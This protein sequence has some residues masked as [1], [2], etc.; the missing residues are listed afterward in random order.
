MNEYDSSKIIDIL[1]ASHHFEC[2]DKPDLADLII[3]NTCAVRDKAETKVYSDL[4]R[5]R[6]YKTINPNLI[7]GVGG[8]L[9][10]QEQEQ[11]FHRAPF[12][13]LVFGPQTLHHLPKMYDQA[14]QQQTKIIDTSFPK[15][16]KFDY[17]PE[18]KVNGPSASITIM[19]GC[20]KFCSYCIVPY[21]RGREISRP[22][23]DI[24]HEIATY[25][26]KKIKEIILLG[27]N[28]N[29]Y[30]DKSIKGKPFR[31]ADLII[32][33]AKLPNIERIRFTTSHPAEIDDNLIAVFANEP[34]L[35]SHIHLPAQ[36][37]SN[38]I[39]AAMRRNYSHE[40]YLEIVTKLRCAR[41][42]I[43][44]SS[45][46]I[47]GFPGETEHDFQDT[48]K[49]I[50]T[51]GFDASFSFI[52]SPRPNTP[53]VKLIDDVT[54]AEKKHRLMHLQNLIAT[55]SRKI[56]HNMIGTSQPILVVGTAK[57]Y[58]NQYTGR[59][60]NN[61]VV[62]FVADA[63]VIGKIIQVTITEVLSNSLVGKVST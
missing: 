6:K 36:S 23:A 33:I 48:L 24:L 54:I 44:I 26:S 62:N 16:E 55:H 40:Q 60:E 5:Y 7:I 57:K 52:Y 63:H 17:F 22:V 46:F 3:L 61:R 29:A 28:V 2:V 39:L 31:L 27:Q 19:E 14:V 35:V 25:Q 15:I 59:T 8:C 4:G 34:K 37:G 21:T 32:T 9:G 10:S 51:V 12:V 13:N 42:N 41:P 45:D 20:N 11:I 58:P 47:V 30:S 38:K 43:C 50:K 18:P 1:S 53:A 56:S 49:L